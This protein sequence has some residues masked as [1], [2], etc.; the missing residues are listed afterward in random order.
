MSLAEWF[1]EQLKTSGD[2]FAW[3]VEQ[4]PVERRTIVPPAPLGEW[5][6]VRHALHMLNYETAIALPIMRYWLGEPF[7]IT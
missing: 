2:G 1:R 7:P 4:V 5:T 6:V 3:A